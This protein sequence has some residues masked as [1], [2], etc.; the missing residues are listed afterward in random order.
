[1]A[2]TSAPLPS[3][4]PGG[5]GLARG[6]L[7]RGFELWSLPAIAIALVVAAPVLV[8]FANLLLPSGGAWAHLAETTL[9][10][11]VANT[12]LLMLGVAVGCATIGVGTA[13]LVTMCR[14]PGSRL[15][16]WMLLLPM[17]M[18][19]YIMAYTYTDLLQF[20][21]PLQGF[22]REAMGWRAG[23]Y[24]FPDIQ[25]LYG[26]VAILTL[27]LYPYVYLL[28]RA[29]FLEQSLAMLEVS[30]TLGHGPWASFAR[31][32][33]PLARPAIAGGTALALMETVNDFGTVQYFGVDTFTTG[34][35]RTWFGMGNKVAAAQLAS[36]L[37]LFVLL[38]L[39]LE[40]ASRGDAR[41]HHT[42]RRYQQLSPARLKGLQAAL[43][44]AACAL[45][46]GLGFVLPAS[47][48]LHMSLTVGDPLFGPRLVGF[49][50]NSFI[51][52]GLA[53]AV[54]AGAALIVAYGVRLRPS[55]VMRGAAR[56][57]AMG[58]AIPGSVIA[59]G[60]LIPLAAFDNL[61][62]A[63]MRAALGVSTGLLVSGTIF[64]LVCAYMA[65]FLAIALNATEAG[66]ARITPSMDE[67]ARTLG[68]G[69][70]GTL[71]K[72]HAPIM[73]G[74]I[75][76]AAIMVFVDVLKEL[77]A[78]LII[79]PFNF[80]TLAVRVYQLASD[81]RLA[82]ASTGALAIVVVGLL[83]VVILSLMIARSRPGGALPRPGRG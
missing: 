21:G 79:R 69:P 53:A 22:L 63:W 34:I 36:V 73:R 14:F 74:T 55:R 57:A 56:V 78:T 37:M 30:R 54:T 13:W 3:P 83:P 10:D 40:R 49:A 20:T 39:V 80:D 19:A 31:L 71:V 24:W 75:L 47:V 45:P 65:R 62:D 50:A 59:V 41:Y 68:Q 42:S 8:V 48:L 17:A 77:P 25:S 23:D 38:V 28:S 2:T 12:L 43:A 9:A 26:A 76:A 61:V 82:Q 58:Y 81:E 51:L 44:L 67:V 5:Q 52:A 4:P 6:L 27:A 72:V 60:I 11:L 64:A 33:L 7:R 32:A 15:C 35:Y 70:A 66:L 46:L 29:A 16:E 1:M 18:P